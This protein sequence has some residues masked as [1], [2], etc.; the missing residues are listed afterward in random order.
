MKDF[1][2]SYE[3]IRWQHAIAEYERLSSYSMRPNFYLSPTFS[4]YVTNR[5][6][7]LVNKYPQ[8]LKE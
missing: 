5:M 1:K 8:L 3:Q 7:E 6:K 4:N 2:N